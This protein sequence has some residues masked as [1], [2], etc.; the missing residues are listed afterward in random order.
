MN[1]PILEEV[2][3]ARKRLWER[4]GCTMSGL[5]EYLRSHP[6]PGVR[7]VRLPGADSAPRKPSRPR[8][9]SRKAPALAFAHG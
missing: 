2:Y 4:G 9:S 5:C 7:Y 3:A 8:A 1:N 6:V